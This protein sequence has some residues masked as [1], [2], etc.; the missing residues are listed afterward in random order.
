MS[1][2]TA[3]RLEMFLRLRISHRMWPIQIGAL[4][5]YSFTLNGLKWPWIDIQG[6]GNS[7][8]IDIGSFLNLRW[9][10][11]N[12]FYIK[13]QAVSTVQPNIL[14]IIRIANNHSV[15]STMMPF[16]CERLPVSRLLVTLS[17]ASTVCDI[18][19]LVCRLKGY[20]IA[21]EFENPL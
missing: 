2:E 9:M 4:F 3:N 5:P 15:L 7:T 6:H 21:D 10:C 12:F 17:Q 19:L 16:R 13:Y 14:I 18:L 8:W 1:R 20:V 11:C